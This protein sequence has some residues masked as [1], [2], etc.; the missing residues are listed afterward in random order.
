MF[1]ESHLLLGG[2]DLWDRRTIVWLDHDKSL[3]K[4][5]FTDIHHVCR[6]IKSGSVLAITVNA[7]AGN[8]KSNRLERIRAFAGAER[9]PHDVSHSSLADWGTARLSRRLI[10]NEILEQVKIRNGISPTGQKLAY[11]QL[12]NF[13]YQDG[14]QML[15]VGGIFFSEDDT[16]K[17]KSS[18]L[19]A[20]HLDF[21]RSGEEPYEILP[22]NLT[23]RE[24]HYLDSKL[25][26]LS[27]EIPTIPL[28]VEDI[29][30]YSA[31]YRYFPRFTESEL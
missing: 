25:P 6:N 3:R 9:I 24:M 2:R 23:L 30:R 20:E 15:T 8:P 12:Y 27:A 31:L 28:P 11:Q 26:N 14:A 1:G 7:Q 16:E 13:H 21:I 17:F 22:P 4:A 10:N 19:N 5:M 18:G 29:D